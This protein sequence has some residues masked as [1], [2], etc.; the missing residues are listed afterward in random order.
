MAKNKNS[1][2]AIAD[3]NP[4]FIGGQLSFEGAEAYKRL[5]TNLQFAVPDDGGCRIV[6]VTSTNRSEG[7]STTAVNLAYTIALDGKRV[8]LIDG[9]LRLPSI[10]AKLNLA[11]APG[12]SNLLSGM[13]ATKDILQRSGIHENLYVISGGDIPPNP[14][15]LLGTKQMKTILDTFAKQVDYII[16][17]LPPIGAVADALVISKFLHGILVVVRMGYASKGELGSVMRQLKHANA[18][19]LG[20]I[21]THNKTSKGS[22]GKKNYYAMEE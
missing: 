11:G 19:V 13:G 3:V 15:E 20:F 7:K 12:L 10:A 6:G 22:Y 14:S 4:D 16:I 5:R 9:D 2:S 18:K 21:T 8:L 17:D 1:G